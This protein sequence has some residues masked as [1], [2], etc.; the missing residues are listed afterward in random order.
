MMMSITRLKKFSVA[1]SLVVAALFLGGCGDLYERDE[2]AKSV[3][4]KSDAEVRKAIGKPAAVDASD[5][6]RVTWT[7]NGATFDLAHGNKRDA[8]TVVVFKPE[9]AGGKLKAAEVLYQ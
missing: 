5:P 6:A 9:A 8:K 7:Y 4:G 2:F 1:A 3:Q